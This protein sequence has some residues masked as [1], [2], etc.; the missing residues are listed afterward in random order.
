MNR[1]RRGKASHDKNPI[2]EAPFVVTQFALTAD[3]AP[4]STPQPKRTWFASER[5]SPRV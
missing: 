5:W 4:R 3:D 1:L 2:G